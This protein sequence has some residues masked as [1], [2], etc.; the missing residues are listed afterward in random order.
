MRL[1][2]SNLIQLQMSALFSVLLFAIL[3]FKILRS[4]LSLFWSG[5]LTVLWLLSGPHGN[6]WSSIW[7]NL[8]AT[9][10]V[11]VFCRASEVTVAGKS[12][13]GFAFFLSANSLLWLAMFTRIHIIAVIFLVMIHFL[14][15]LGRL[16]RKQYLFTQILSAGIFILFATF[17][18]ILKP[19]FHQ[20]IV[21]AASAYIGKGSG[22][23]ISRIGDLSFVVLVP[24]VLIVLMVII[25]KLEL[26]GTNLESSNLLAMRATLN[27]MLVSF[28]VFVFIMQFI[29]KVEPFTLLNPQVFAV[30]FSQ[31][32]FYAF[33]FGV[34]CSFCAFSIAL[35]C[36]LLRRQ[37][38]PNLWDFL[39]LGMLTQLYPLQDPYHIFVIVPA[40]L[41]SLARSYTERRWDLPSSLSALMSK[42]SL[43]SMSSIFTFVLL[44]QTLLL[45][46]KTDHRFSFGIL[47]GMYSRSY[48]AYV[49]E[50]RMNKKWAKDLE[51]TIRELSKQK[52]KGK[53]HFFC[54]EGLFSA[55]SGQYLPADEFYVDWGP[56]PDMREPAPFEF[57]CN[58][59]REELN[60]LIANG[61]TIEIITRFSASPLNSSGEQFYVLLR[62][63]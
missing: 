52:I 56:V 17:T 37:S 1:F 62:R 23:S 42:L 57:H 54:K 2:G 28:A 20:C 63:S 7:S 34:L 14:I 53:V 43:R 24:S 39:A 19:W 59:S 31:K 27:A 50:G 12:K 21:W 4:S 58:L 46:L 40:L 15:G 36:R 61:F 41:I 16:H 18:G 45:G 30:T 49:Q 22:L 48:S 29:R 25:A 33:T 51:Q 13:L 32:F 8:F 9:L 5:I 44:I 55:A 47:E 6:P 3:L 10:S 11:W 26:L 38:L 60:L 35:L